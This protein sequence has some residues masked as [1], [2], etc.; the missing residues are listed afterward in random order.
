MV[1]IYIIG[2]HRAL[3]D[4]L[5]MEK[6]FTHPSLVSCLSKLPTR[7]P[8]KQMTAWIEQKRLFQ[9][10]TAL[11]KSLGKPSITKTQAKRLDTLGLGYE[12]LSKLR[13]T[14]KDKEVFM[15]ALKDKG[16]N[17]KPLREKLSKILHP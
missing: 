3:P 5:A 13:C 9:R 17:S 16:V 4:I 11:V 6:V 14:H 1:T 2:A 10:I 7:S 12:D 8:K 15:Q